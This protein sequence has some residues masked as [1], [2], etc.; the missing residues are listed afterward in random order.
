MGHVPKRHHAPANHSRAAAGLAPA[1][2]CR[3]AGVRG[4]GR[5]RACALETATRA[6]ENANEDACARETQGGSHLLFTSDFRFS[7]GGTGSRPLRPEVAVQGGLQSMHHMFCTR[8]QPPRSRQGD[9]VASS[10]LQG[11]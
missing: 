9:G 1:P 3:A 11:S 7:P 8:P 10:A 4:G 5:K 2:S 6:D